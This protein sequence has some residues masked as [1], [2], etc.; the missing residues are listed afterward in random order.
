MTRTIDEI[1]G[2]LPN[3]DQDEIYQMADDLIAEMK[4]ND[5]SRGEA[6]ILVPSKTQA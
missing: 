5:K 2:N 6:K 1:I 4:V 3:K